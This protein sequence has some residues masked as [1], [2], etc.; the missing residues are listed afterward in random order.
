MREILKKLIK[1][2]RVLILGYGR[3]GKSTLREIVNAGGY[4]CVA[5]SDQKEVTDVLPEG[6][7]RI[8]G[9]GYLE[10]I[11]NYDVV[12][13]SPGIVLPRNADE[14]KALITS[15]MD[16]FLECYRGRSIGVTGTKG[17]ST[18]SSLLAHI[19]RRCGKSVLFAGNIGIPV[20]DIWDDVREDSVIVL[21]M[22]CHQ[23]EYIKFAPRVSLLLNIYEDHLDHYGT[24][25]KYAAAKKN[26][27]LKQRPG[28][29]L[30]T[31]K[32]TAAECENL[33][34]D[35]NF[36]DAGM[37]PFEDFS[38]V[39][40]KLKGAHN[41]LN[42]AFVYETVKLFGINQNEFIKA[43]RSFEGLPHRLQLLGEADGVEYYDDSIST[44]VMSAISAV[45]SVENAGIIILGGMERNLDYTELIEYLV[46]SRLDRIIFM[47]ASGKRMYD[48]Y[49][50]ALKMHFR[51][52]HAVYCED[53]KAAVK[54][55]KEN[56][57]KGT[58]VLLSPASA[59]Y[60]HFKNFEERGDVFKSLVF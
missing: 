22:S 39:G 23:L 11:D 18:T 40:S 13:K 47:Y 30:F 29:I 25:E 27:Y 3:E 10:C 52:P 31:T 55:A 24:R 5:I 21:E 14:Y 6:V 20:F 58:A 8:Y 32:E 9:S 36:V 37:M 38:E 56:A 45:E 42:A 59:S 33:P 4:E 44:T 49:G 7:K 57:R 51:S 35:V 28:D 41:V 60:D 26:I 48:M 19:L 50:K 16:V 43:L 46:K 2:R 34:P 15:E 12:F 53:I 54:D 1:N 17:K